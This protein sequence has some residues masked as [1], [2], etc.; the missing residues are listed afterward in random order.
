MAD[1]TKYQPSYSFTDFQTGSPTQPL[2]A[3]QVDNELANVA[4]SVNA[5]IDA[6]K[7]VRRSD[8]ALKNAVVTPDSLS[9]ATRSLMANLGTPRGEWATATAYAVKDFVSFEG[10]TYAAVSAHTSSATFSTDLDAG[11]WLLIASPY[12][13]SGAVFSQV[14]DGDGVTT[15]FALSQPFNSIE[16]LA[17]YVQDGS[18]GYERLRSSGASPQV[19]LVG[20]T[21]LTFSA[22]PGV[23]TR[24]VFAE[25]INQTA[26]ESAAVAAVSATTATT[27]AGVATTKADEASAYATAAATSETNASAHEAAAA[28]SAT[29]AANVVNGVM[30]RDVVYK[31]FVDSPVV[32]DATYGG[33]MVVI[34]TSGGSVVVN[35]P[36]ITALTLPWSVAFQKQTSDANTVTINRNGADTIGGATS[37]ALTAEDQGAILVADDS[38]SPDDWTRVGFGEPVPDLSVTTAKLAARAVTPAKMQAVTQDRLLGR[39]SPGSGDQEEIQLGAGLAFSGG[40]LTVTLS[41]L[42]DD[43]RYQAL[44]NALVERRKSGTQGGTGLVKGHV[45]AYLSDTI[46]SA[47]TNETYDATGDYYANPGTVTTASASSKWAGGTGDWTF[48]GD[49]LEVSANDNCIYT[50][51]EFTGDFEFSFKYKSDE[52]NVSEIGVFAAS[53]KGSVNPNSSSQSFTGWFWQ[54]HAG[55]GLADPSAGN[56]NAGTTTSYSMAAVVDGDTVTFGR[57][58]TSIWVKR[59]GSL[60]HTFATTSSATLCAFVSQANGSTGHFLDV[61][62]TVP[63]TPPDMTL[64]RGSAVAAAATP[65]TAWAVA[66]V[67]PVSSITYNTDYTLE[68]T[69][70]SGTNWDAVTLTNVG[71]YDGTYDILVGKVALTGGSTN[72]NYRKK[73]L[74]GKELRDAGIAMMWG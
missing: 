22:A 39:A 27:Q 16:E 62:W 49:D 51:D 74:N 19:S 64:T 2:P 56:I 38:S 15:A 71:S 73:S 55:D 45:D 44:L 37:T 9:P 50:V 3:P 36:Y 46:G 57:T 61:S 53:N 30:W 60:V 13:I 28:A 1:P 5:T 48:P 72:M 29:A 63:G 31:T 33:K 12:S 8:G 4:T 65:A 11:L 6:M 58:G 54:Q 47:S 17:V 23:G 70:N 14:F 66:L 43:A 26:A 18:A 68:V 21:Q 42:D 40:A 24:N 41:P 59:N 20:T 34:D 32:I 25:A 69:S 10:A 67:D 7:D 35:L 52:L